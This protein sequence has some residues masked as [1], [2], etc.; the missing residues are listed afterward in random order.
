MILFAVIF[1]SGGH[2][3]WFHIGHLK[4]TRI[5]SVYLNV[6]TSIFFCIDSYIL[7]HTLY[8]LFNRKKLFPDHTEGNIFSLHSLEVCFHLYISHPRFRKIGH[9]HHTPCAT[10]SI[11]WILGVS[12]PKKPGSS[13]SGN[14]LVFNSLLGRKIIPFNI[15]F[16]G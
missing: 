4:K 12:Y 3:W 11:F 10:Y 1:W 13:V 7:I 6:C 9:C 2:L 16:F 8:Q 15:V 14:K 5:V